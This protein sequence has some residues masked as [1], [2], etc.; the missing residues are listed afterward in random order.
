MAYAAVR[1]ARPGPCL[2]P[3]LLFLHACALTRQKG[4][5]PWKD[6]VLRWSHPAVNAAYEQERFPTAK[7]Y[8]SCI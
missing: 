8:C 7:G 4:F 6:K 3:H 2:D 1:A 5:D